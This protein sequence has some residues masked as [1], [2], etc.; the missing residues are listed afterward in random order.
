VAPP[1]GSEVRQACGSQPDRRDDSPLTTFP[2]L[3][4]PRPSGPELMLMRAL[5]LRS[6]FR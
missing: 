4:V 5:A 2:L 3:V 1:L 6:R